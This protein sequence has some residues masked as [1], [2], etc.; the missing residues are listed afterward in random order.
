M[1]EISSVFK[2]LLLLSWSWGVEVGHITSD[3]M[4]FSRTQL[5]LY[6]C[7]VVLSLSLI[8]SLF[9]ILVTRWLQQLEVH[10]PCG[11]REVAFSLCSALSVSKNFTKVYPQQTCHETHRSY[12]VINPHLH[13]S[14]RGG[15]I[16]PWLASSLQLTWWNKIRALPA[17]Q[18]R[19]TIE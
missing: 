9:F 6:L 7:L 8:L 19:N 3:S 17:C 16:P 5:F 1:P 12:W 13:Y 10:T 4:V 18:G 11:R 14:L 2:L 15:R